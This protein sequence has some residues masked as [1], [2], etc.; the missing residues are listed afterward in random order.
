VR[1]IAPRSKHEIEFPPRLLK[2]WRQQSGVF[3]EDH[4]ATGL[5]EGTYS[6]ATVLLNHSEHLLQSPDG[7]VGLWRI[8]GYDRSEV[9][10][11]NDANLIHRKVSLLV[12]TARLPGPQA[13]LATLYF[14]SRNPH[15]PPNLEERA[16]KIV[17]DWVP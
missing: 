17:E 6:I 12:A 15:P 3:D 2:E 14:A 8:R 10:H 13:T 7:I 5:L 9:Q 16:K 11:I 4:A 1:G